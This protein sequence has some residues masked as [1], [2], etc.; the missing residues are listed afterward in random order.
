MRSQIF[1][2]VAVHNYED[3]FS[4]QCHVFTKI[5]FQYLKDYLTRTLSVR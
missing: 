2:F 5:Q 1:D 3:F 4:H